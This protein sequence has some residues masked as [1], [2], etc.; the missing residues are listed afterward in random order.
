[1]ILLKQ[2]YVQCKV[3]NAML[4]SLFSLNT[5]HYTLPVS[6]V[7][8]EYKWYCATKPV[9]NSSGILSPQVKAYGG[10]WITLQLFSY[11][12]GK[13]LSEYTTV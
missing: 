8:S 1:M 5:S 3:A 12:S 7:L 13:L 11:I 6:F 10:F 9:Y 4:F 2:C